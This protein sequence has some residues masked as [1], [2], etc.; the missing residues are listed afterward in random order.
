MGMEQRTA[1]ARVEQI[2]TEVVFELERDKTRKFTFVE[3]KFLNM[4]YIR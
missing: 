4:W 3:M 2:I 1:H